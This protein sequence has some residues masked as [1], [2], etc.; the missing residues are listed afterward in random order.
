MPLPPPSYLAK[1]KEEYD[2]SDTSDFHVIVKLITKDH[3]RKVKYIR[4]SIRDEH[5]PG[6]ELNEIEDIDYVTELRVDAMQLLWPT[7]DWFESRRN[8]IRSIEEAL[9]LGHKEVMHHG[10]SNQGKTSSFAMI[11]CYMW[12]ENPK[13]ASVYL[14]SPTENATKDGLWANVQEFFYEAKESDPSLPGEVRESAAMIW[15]DKNPRS[16]IQVVTSHKVGRMV[17]R[18]ARMD[19]K[20][21]SKELMLFMA[22][23]L[24]DFPNNSIVDVLANLTS[25]DRFVFVGAGNFADPNDALG[26]LSLPGR[27]GGYHALDVELDHRWL[28]KRGGVCYRYDG[29]R[30]PNYLLGEDKY[31]YLTTIKYLKNLEKQSNGQTGFRYMRFGRSFPCLGSDSQYLSNANRMKAGLAY[32]EE[33]K[34]FHWTGGSVRRSGFC[35]PGFG[36]DD[37]VVYILKYGKIFDREVGKEVWHAHLDGPPLIIPIDTTLYMGKDLN[38]D[39]VFTPERQVVEFCVKICN[40]RG[41]PY[42]NFGFDPSL[43]GG[44]TRAFA[45]FGDRDFVPVDSFGKASNRSLGITQQ[46]YDKKNNGNYHETVLASHRYSNFLTEMAFGVALCVD[47]RQLSGF[48]YCEAT[49]EQITSR[50]WENR[51]GKQIL[52]KKKDWKEEHAGRSPNELDC[53]M[54]VLEMA[55]RRGFQLKNAKGTGG[56]SKSY[57]TRPGSKKSFTST[58]LAGN[59]KPRSFSKSKT[60]NRNS[61]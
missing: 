58:L 7:Y 3:W 59:N 60:L 33:G 43:R 52:Q 25:V 54:G 38:D 8:M 27:D 1:V 56:G 6:K 13:F 10:A 19:T 20:T 47:N 42:K 30:S 57:N 4:E 49:V 17:G 48:Q 29:H 51:T 9:Q 55:R 50:K 11:S 22:D 39:N 34:D 28:T 14:V 31:K 16:F 18:K 35:D 21:E 40:E 61:R 5:F 12:F 24:P 46:M 45:V 37:A 2:T 26:V 32:A 23:E 53:L 15:M 44:I 36:G 41:I